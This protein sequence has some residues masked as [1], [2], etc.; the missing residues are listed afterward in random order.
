MV[1]FVMAGLVA[2]TGCKDDD[3][4]KPTTAKLTGTIT[5]EEV[6]LWETWQDSGEVQLSLFPEFSLDPLAGWGQ[7]S[8]LFMGPAG[9][10]VFVAVLQRQ[11]GTTQYEFEID[12][13]DIEDPVSF[14]A[15]AVGFRHDL[16][17]DP[18]LRT[19]SLGVWWNNED[20][21]SHGIMIRPAPG[22]PPIFDEPAPESFTVEPGDELELNFKADFGFVEE[23]YN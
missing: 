6:E 17:V 21:V 19:A 3:E 5:F 8:D 18:S 11:D 2:T 23:W 9:A 10:P 15:I 20:E 7:T 16:I 1:L 12:I 13:T 14:S 4:P 22:A